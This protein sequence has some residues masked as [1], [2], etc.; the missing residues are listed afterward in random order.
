VFVL[1]LVPIVGISLWVEPVA[2]LCLAGLF[3]LAVLMQ[4]TDKRG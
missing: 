4:K 1:V 2:A 3:G